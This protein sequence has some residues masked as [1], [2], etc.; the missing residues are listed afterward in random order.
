MVKH[1]E[2][3]RANNMVFKYMSAVLTL[4]ILF[5]GCGENLPF[6]YR[7]LSANQVQIEYQ[8]NTYHLNRFGPKSNTPFKYRFEPDG[9]LDI[10]IAGKTFDIDSPYDIDSPKSKKKKKKKKKS[11]KTKK[12]K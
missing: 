12:K 3:L 6:A 8:G 5:W 11:S 10:M 9:D 1:L 4:V 2:H 7:Y